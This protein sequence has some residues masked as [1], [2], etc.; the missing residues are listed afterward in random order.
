MRR[1][2]LEFDYSALVIDGQLWP[3]WKLRKVVP[4]TGEYASE[5]GFAVVESIAISIVSS[6][7]GRE[8]ERAD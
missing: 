4:Q 1:Q 5:V 8:S 2:R 7:M 3:T 6:L